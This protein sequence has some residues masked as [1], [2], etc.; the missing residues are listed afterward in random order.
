MDFMLRFLRAI[1]A[2]LARIF[3]SGIFLVSGI[4]QIIYWKE[5]EK[6]FMDIIAEWQTYTV[7]FEELQTI[8]GLMAVWAPLLLI[9]MTFL[10]IL[11]ALLLFFGMKERLGA[12][13]LILIL[14]PT[15]ILVQHFWFSESSVRELQLS[16]FLRDLAIL[17]GLLVMILQGTQNKDRIEDF[18]KGQ[19]FG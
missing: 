4:N 11:G 3:L 10:E 2:I 15:T 14:I 9:V 12:A 13:L 6:R 16:L 18:D 17:G 7:S 8:F 1:T 5:T 19:P